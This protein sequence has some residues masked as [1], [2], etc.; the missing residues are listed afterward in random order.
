LLLFNNNKLKKT[1]LD[2]RSSWR[3]IK[4]KLWWSMPKSIKFAMGWTQ[5]WQ[6]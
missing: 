6:T 3:S 5:T 4:N 2:Q 1:G